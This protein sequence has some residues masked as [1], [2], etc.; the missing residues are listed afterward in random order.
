[1]RSQTNARIDPRQ[2][3]RKI[4]DLT[5]SPTKPTNPWAFFLQKKYRMIGFL[6]DFSKFDFSIW[7]RKIEHK[8][9][10]QRGLLQRSWKPSNLKRFREFESRNFRQNFYQKMEVDSAWNISLQG[11]KISL[12]EWQHLPNSPRKGRGLKHHD[13][14]IESAVSKNKELPIWP[15]SSWAVKT[16]NPTPNPASIS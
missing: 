11:D 16:E 6:R 8:E 1:M 13:C 5:S 7:R 2:I 15:G 10:W 12:G 3:S 14:R 4:I 9:V